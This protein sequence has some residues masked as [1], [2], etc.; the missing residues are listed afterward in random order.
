MRLKI[1]KNYS[2]NSFMYSSKF[3]EWSFSYFLPSQTA[4]IVY[5]WVFS[6]LKIEWTNFEFCCRKL[7]LAIRFE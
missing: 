3:S 6:D 4:A 1:T 5:V 2:P 7:A